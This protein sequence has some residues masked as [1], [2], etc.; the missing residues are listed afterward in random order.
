MVRKQ[1]SRKMKLSI[2]R[3]ISDPTLLENRFPLQGGSAPWGTGW[4]A[5][6]PGREL[7]VKL[8]LRLERSQWWRPG[9]LYRMP[10]GRCSQHVPRRGDPEEEPQEV[11]GLPSLR[12][13]WIV[14][15]KK[16]RFRPKWFLSLSVTCPAV[17]GRMQGD[18]LD[19]SPAYAVLQNYKEQVSLTFRPI[20]F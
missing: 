18:S 3:S 5:Q 8:F 16:M 2:Y 17:T 1:L 12:S 19:K 10:P 13:D 11:W 15:Q 20:L 4:G 6:S 7:G 14:C 9:H